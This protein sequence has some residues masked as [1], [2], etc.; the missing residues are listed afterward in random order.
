MKLSPL[1]RHPLRLL[2]MFGLLLAGAAALLSA[3]GGEEEKTTVVFSDLNWTSS[4]IQ[5]RVAAFIV[6]HGYGYPQS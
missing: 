1:L 2:L 6:E 4:E 5:V 3:C